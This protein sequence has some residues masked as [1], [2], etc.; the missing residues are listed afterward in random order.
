M[1]CLHLDHRLR[2]LKAWANHEKRSIGC[3]GTGRKKQ[4]RRPPSRQTG[5]RGKRQMLW[6]R[7]RAQKAHSPLPGAQCWLCVARSRSQFH[8]SPS[9]KDKT[10]LHVRESQMLSENG[11]LSP[12]TAWPSTVYKELVIPAGSSGATEGGARPPPQ[13]GPK[14]EVS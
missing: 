12:S 5:S 8:L 9:A 1:P 13:W 2:K 7:A 10:F 4:G 14:H 11:H 6:K 3:Y